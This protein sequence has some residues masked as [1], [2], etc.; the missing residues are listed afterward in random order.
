MAFSVASI[1]KHVYR[2]SPTD[3]FSAFVQG[4]ACTT[5]SVPPSGWTSNI[6]ATFTTAGPRVDFT[7]YGEVGPFAS[8]SAGL[9][10]IQGID[11]NVGVGAAAHLGN[12]LRVLSIIELAFEAGLRAQRYDR[13]SVTM[14]GALL[15][16]RLHM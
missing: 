11:T 13:A 1:E 14:G 15:S 8:V 9:A 16:A 12:R 5:C 2:N 7:P 10:A 4:A 3:R 6:V